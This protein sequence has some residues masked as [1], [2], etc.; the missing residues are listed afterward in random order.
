M[1]TACKTFGAV[2]VSEAVLSSSG[3][4]VPSTHMSNVNDTI[5]FRND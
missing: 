5:A 2:I 4:D 1:C 3:D